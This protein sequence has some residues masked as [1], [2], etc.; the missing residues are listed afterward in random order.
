MVFEISF[1][2]ITVFQGY[3]SSPAASHA[4]SNRPSSLET[5][6]FIVFQ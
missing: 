3:V 5:L 2:Q 4:N 6:I 1:T